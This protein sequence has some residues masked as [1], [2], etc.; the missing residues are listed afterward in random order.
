MKV[1]DDDAAEVGRRLFDPRQELNLDTRLAAT[2]VHRATGDSDRLCHHAS[3]VVGQ[4]TNTKVT[5][6]AVPTTTMK[7]R[8]TLGGRWR[9]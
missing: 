9:P 3:R 7:A 8:S 2:R 4:E 1:G 6:A 5:M